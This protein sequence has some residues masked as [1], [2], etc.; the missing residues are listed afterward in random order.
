[1]KSDRYRVFLEPQEKTAG[2][3]GYY[4][5]ENHDGKKKWRALR[6]DEGEADAS[7]REK[8]EENRLCGLPNEIP[9]KG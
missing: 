2:A 7:V 9:V 8:K 4:H 5:I 3:T 6:N 1:M